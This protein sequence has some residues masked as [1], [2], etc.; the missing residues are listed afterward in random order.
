MYYVLKQ[1]DVKDQNGK[2]EGFRETKIC[3]FKS[4]LNVSTY[5]LITHL[6][7]LGTE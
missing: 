5:W 1:V 7:L 3:F 2:R 6:M 4:V